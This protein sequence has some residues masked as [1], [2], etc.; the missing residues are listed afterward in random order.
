MRLKR[1]EGLSV[2]AA[3]EQVRTELGPGAL[4]LHTKAVP[5]RGL[6]GL[7]GR[8]V[9]EVL[10]AVDEESAPSPAPDAR[11]A[12]LA[13]D[14]RLSAWSDG[15][16][17]GELEEIRTLL[18]RLAARVEAVRPADAAGG[19]EALR[20]IVEQLVVQEV[21][22]AA[23]REAVA[24]LEADLQQRPA[25]ETRQVRARLVEILARGIRANGAI[26][27]THGP[28]AVALVGP[29][30][31]GKTTTLAKL[32]ARFQIAEK[33]RVALVTLDT[34]RIGAVDQLRTYA[35]ILGLPL[36]VA[37]T[38]A[39][40]E[41]ALAREAGAD[42]VL[43]DTVGRSYRRAGE[44]EALQSF[45]S[46]GGIETHLVLSATTKRADLLDALERYR[47][48]G[49]QRLILSKLDETRCFG[50]AVEA[51]RVAGVPL[52]Y[53]ATGQEVPDDLEEASALK[54][55]RLLVEGQ[56]LEAVAA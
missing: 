50:P 54:L 8:E 27:L 35:E 38:A 16:P 41:R 48:V 56:G 23:A 5:R 46:V 29:T 11:A 7:L 4:I 9:V 3:L 15:A 12:S 14:A 49:Y 42:L 43:I 26:R 28:K 2:A 30:G 36:R 21:E 32:A 52:A 20:G 34:Y 55:G 22:P 24:L 37:G 17:R 19:P 45:L 51:C 44:V 6:G 47:A 10:A 18:E 40:L 25:A 1:F 33:K 31:V 53:F 13:G 39:E